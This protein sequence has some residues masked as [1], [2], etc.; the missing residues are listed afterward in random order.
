MEVIDKAFS[1]WLPDSDHPDQAREV[2]EEYNLANALLDQF[3][4]GT[5]R[6]DEYIEGIANLPIDI[7]QYI[8]DVTDNLI[9]LGN[10]NA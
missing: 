6:L 5:L 8:D 10:L 3:T 2:L 4:N 1:L 7:D 9:Y